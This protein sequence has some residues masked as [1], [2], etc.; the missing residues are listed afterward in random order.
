MQ[1]RAN[2]AIIPYIIIYRVKIRKLTHPKS[3]NE[4]QNESPTEMQVGQD[5]DGE[6]YLET[7]FIH[8]GEYEATN[9][10][11][12]YNDVPTVYEQIEH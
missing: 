8:D 12:D 11:S 4:G 6:E 7:D 9:L 3:A 1:S 5:V 2:D 10:T